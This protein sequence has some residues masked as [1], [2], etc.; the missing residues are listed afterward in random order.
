MN[1]RR[2]KPAACNW[3]TWPYLTTCGK[4]V[5]GTIKQAGYCADHISK[6]VAMF[7][8]MTPIAKEEFEFEKGSKFLDLAAAMR[9]A[10]G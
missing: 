5:V 2:S 7:G 8:P 3:L 6:A 4:D 10:A 1:S 9:K